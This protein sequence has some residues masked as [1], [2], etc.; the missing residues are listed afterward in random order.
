MYNNIMSIMNSYNAMA[1]RNRIVFEALRSLRNE[2]HGALDI[3]DRV[4][5]ARLIGWT[6]LRCIERRIAEADTILNNHPNT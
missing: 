6:N 5:V 3:A 4:E 1:D 2:I